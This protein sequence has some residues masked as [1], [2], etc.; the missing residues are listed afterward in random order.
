M[1]ELIFPPEVPQVGQKVR[2]TTPLGI[3][4]G[5]VSCRTWSIKRNSFSINVPNHLVES[6]TY[7]GVPLEWCG[8]FTDDVLSAIEAS[9]QGYSTSLSIAVID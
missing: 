8:C 1:S 7:E 2:I 4:E 3:V 9:K 6:I 5:I